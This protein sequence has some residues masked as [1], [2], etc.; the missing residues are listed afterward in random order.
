MDLRLSNK[1]AF[2][3]GG[4]HGI[5]L[6]IA[7]YLGKEGCDVII[8]SRTQ[9][10]LDTASSILSEMNIK[11]LGL[12]CDV[13]IKQD[14]ENCID[15]IN[16]KVGV[17]D[18]LI[19]N[20]GGGGSWG[21][22]DILST[23]E[24]VWDEVYDKNVTAAVKFTNGFLSGMLNNNWG[25]VITITSTFGLEA[26]GRPWF[27]LAKTAQTALMKNY[28][29]NKKF[30]KNGVTFNSVAPGPIDI[31]ETGWATK[32]LEPDFEEFINTLIP[33]GRLGKP[34]DIACIVA[35]LASPLSNYINGAS[36]TV[37]GGTSTTF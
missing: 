5:G 12:K 4:T 14:I 37:D 9:E 3:S 16:D 30:V 10:R 26:G 19:N 31:P 32:K 11:T 8:C 20:V 36:I 6:E 18:I 23:D 21:S 27:N 22:E 25:R 34:E 29:K 17:I 15:Y 28:S 13:N 7:K 33:M 35:F 24:N 1:K 2:I